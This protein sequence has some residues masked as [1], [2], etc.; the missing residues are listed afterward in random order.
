LAAL[1]F[2]PSGSLDVENG[3]FAHQVFKYW[4]LSD[5]EGVALVR[6]L[7]NGTLKAV[8]STTAKTP[9]GMVMLNRLAALDWL[10]QHRTSRVAYLSVPQAANALRLK[11]QVVYELVARKLLPTECGK[12]GERLVTMKALADFTSTYVSLG[13]LSKRLDTSPRALLRKLAVLPVCGPTVD[14]V[15]Q[16]FYRRQDVGSLLNQAAVSES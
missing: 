8:G 16:Y 11:Q 9:L 15:R 10:S 13:A 14:G 12:H 7:Q 1:F 2:C 3:I 6:A 5:V 4:R